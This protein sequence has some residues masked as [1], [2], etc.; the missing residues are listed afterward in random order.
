MVTPCTCV[1][2]F[3]E[4]YVTS[5]SIHKH[6][7]FISS[8]NGSCEGGLTCSFD[9]KEVT[10]FWQFKRR[11]SGKIPQKRAVATVGKQDNNNTW[12]LSKDLQISQFNGEA[13]NPADSKYIWLG[14]LLQSKG[15]A[16][17]ANAIYIPGPLTTDGL[18]ALIETMHTVM[19]HN[20]SASLMVLGCACMAMHYKTIIDVNGECPAPFVCG[21]VGTGKSLALRAALSMFGGHKTRFYSRGTREK[22]QLLLSQSTFP[23]GIDDPQRPDSIGE[24]MIDLFNGAKSTTVTH[25]DIQPITSG[26]VTANFNLAQRAQ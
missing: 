10:Q 3:R 23:V 22:Y 4:S 9:N 18:H 16:A 2:Y 11:K 21:D 6:Q 20:F 7:D 26:I 25:G 1:F 13:I 5:D 8:I 14:H 17:N 24:L 19:C 12:V 15:I